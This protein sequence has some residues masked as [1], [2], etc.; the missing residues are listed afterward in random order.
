VLRVAATLLALLTALGQALAAPG[1]DRVL[2]VCEDPNNLPF[3]NRA[4]EGFENKV[5]ELLAA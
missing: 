1:D 5:V 4:G 2:R 3:S